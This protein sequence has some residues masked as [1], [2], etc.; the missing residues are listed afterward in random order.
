M[1]SRREDIPILVAHFLEQH[2]SR[3]GIAV[4]ALKKRHI[5]ELSRYDWPG[6]IRELQNVVERAIIRSRI[7]PLQFD[8][9]RAGQTRTPARNPALDT[10]QE[11]LTYGELRKLEFD[12]V[13][14]VLEKH[15]WKISGPGGAAEFLGV[16][17]AT[18]S[19]RMRAMGIQRTR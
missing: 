6:N 5:A 9:P 16:H 14:A 8:L 1:R 18:L 11:L 12:N 10:S 7:G 17:P 19:S 13:L 2:G 4:P 3:L 15:H